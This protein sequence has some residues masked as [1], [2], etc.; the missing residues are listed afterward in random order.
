METLYKF[1]FDCGRQGELTGLFIADKDRLEK[2]VR[3]KVVCYFWEAL[4][5][6]S[7]VDWPIEQADYTEVSSDPTVIKVIK[8]LWLETGYNPLDYLDEEYEG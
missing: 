5:K 1:H 6:H 4:G 3:D 8:D 2:I 7:E